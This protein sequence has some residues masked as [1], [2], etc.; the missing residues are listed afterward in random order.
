VDTFDRTTCSVF[1]CPS[2]N[3]RWVYRLRGCGQVDPEGRSWRSGAI[4]EQ[5]KLKQWFLKVTDFADELVDDLDGLSQWP[6]QVKLMQKSWIGRSHGTVIKFPVSMSTDLAALPT[7]LDAFTTRPDTLAGVTFVAIA[8]DHPL[9]DAIIASVKASRAPSD[10]LSSLVGTIHEL[11]RSCATTSKVEG[12]LLGE[13][14]EAVRLPVLVEHPI[15]RQQVRGPVHTR[16]QWCER[17]D[18][19]LLCM[20]GKNCTAR[21]LVR[22]FIDVVCRHRGRTPQLPAARVCGLV[23]VV[24]VRHWRGYGQPRT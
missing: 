5:R 23:C 9:I 3:E 1:S 18:G 2:S 20:S 12:G 4:V 13:D 17:Q 19:G 22:V 16:D 8:P 10:T 21:N 6:E 11:Q 24:F 14:F 15:T 7:S